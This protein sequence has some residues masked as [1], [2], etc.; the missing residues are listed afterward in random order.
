MR[1]TLQKESPPPWLITH[2]FDYVQSPTHL[3][4]ARA[5]NIVSW[6][7]KSCQ[8]A[9]EYLQLTYLKYDYRHLVF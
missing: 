7:I 8:N 5:T 6:H 1:E 9:F 3:Q 2:R 4:I